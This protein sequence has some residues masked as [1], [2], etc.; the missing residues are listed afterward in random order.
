MAKT[1]AFYKKRGF[2]TI[3]LA[4][5]ATVTFVGSAIYMFDVD[6]KVMLQFFLVSVLGLA[7]LIFAALIFTAIRVFFRRWLS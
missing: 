4:L 1:V 7:L 6:P 3:L 5:F 2:R